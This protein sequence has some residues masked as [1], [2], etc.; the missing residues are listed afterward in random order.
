[1]RERNGTRMSVME[2][3]IGWVLLIG[4]A[5]A[6][7]LILVALVWQWIVSGSPSL[8]FQFQGH[9][10]IEVLVGAP[11]G[12]GEP[13]AQ[14]LAR[15]GLGLLI[16]TPYVRVLTSVIFFAVAEHDWKYVGFTTF[17]AAVVTWS[18]FFR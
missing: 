4:V 11:G 3:A 12:A 8:V 10:L 15:L 16:L 1:M 9:S 13:I 17:V 18:L 7:G 6:A 5:S 2:E 14:V